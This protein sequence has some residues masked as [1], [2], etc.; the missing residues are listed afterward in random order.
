MA[1]ITEAAKEARRA[2]QRAWMAAH[3]DK[4]REYAKKNMATYWQR[5]AE[6]A[7]AAAEAQDPATDPERPSNSTNII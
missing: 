3:E 5:K 6:K 4:C 1:N 2:Y 7:K